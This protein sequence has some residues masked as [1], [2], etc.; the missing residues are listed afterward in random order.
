MLDA[1]TQIEVYTANTADAGE[2]YA[3]RLVFDGTLMNFVLL[4][5]MCVRVSE[6]LRARIADIAWNQIKDFRNLVAHDYMG[7]DSMMENDNAG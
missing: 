7:T 3:D 5:E 4:G 6:D 2:F 1:M